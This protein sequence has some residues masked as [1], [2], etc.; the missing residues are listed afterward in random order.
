MKKKQT[1]WIVILALLLVLLI[2]LAIFMGVK[3]AEDP[4]GTTAPTTGSVPSTTVRPTQ[5]PTTVPTQPATTAPPT[6]PAT[7]VPPTQPATTAPTV[8]A[9]TVPPTQPPVTKPP[10]TEPTTVPTEPVKAQP[11]DILALVGRQMAALKGTSQAADAVENPLKLTLSVST[12]LDA[13]AAA[14]EM[15]EL[16]KSTLGYDEAKAD[17]NVPVG[18][19]N[20]FS[21][22]YKLIHT[23]T[24]DGQHSFE[25]QY[26][27]AA[28]NYTVTAQG[29]DTNK[30]TAD[31]CAYLNSI[32]KKK[33]DSQTASSVSNAQPV[34]VLLERDYETVL[35]TVKAQVESASVKYANYDFYYK[36][37]TVSVKDGQ[38]K[39]AL[40]FYICNQ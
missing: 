29:Y 32:G 21:Y 15:M 40:L 27:F 1:V 22:T 14:K 31:I 24:A 26:R 6:Q 28:P 37:L 7:T 9:T 3:Q 10:V 30:L 8:P 18:N 19:P 16:I 23:Q 34:I 13:E 39:E 17:P 4:N 35:S 11:N 5:Q 12:Q 2:G 20:P 25:L 38:Q 36:A 33:F